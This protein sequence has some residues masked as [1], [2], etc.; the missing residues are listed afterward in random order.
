MEIDFALPVDGDLMAGY[1]RYREVSAK[2]VMDYAFHMAVTTWNDKVGPRSSQ[3]LRPSLCAHEEAYAV[4][5]LQLTAACNAVWCSG[6]LGHLVV[7][8]LA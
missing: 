5:D 6:R 7:S 8:H 2:S 4:F 1:K 3:P